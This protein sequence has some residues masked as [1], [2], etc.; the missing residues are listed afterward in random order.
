[1]PF[2]VLWSAD[3]GR[4]WA[5]APDI[6]HLGG[7]V[8]IRQVF[9]PEELKGLCDIVEGWFAVERGEPVFSG[10]A[11]VVPD[12]TDDPPGRSAVENAQCKDTRSTQLPAE[13][14][15]PLPLEKPDTVLAR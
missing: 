11:L 14:E 12:A 2:D 8:S 10:D 3:I 6:T 4:E 9:V 5:D 15:Q 7:H 1:M 13:P